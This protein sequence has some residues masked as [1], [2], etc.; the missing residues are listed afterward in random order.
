MSS[1]RFIIIDIDYLGYH[2]TSLFFQVVAGNVEVTF[3]ARVSMMR[4]NDT[5]SRCDK[6]IDSGLISI[7]LEL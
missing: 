6:F 7:H 4:I 1:I 2:V 3:Q 5:L